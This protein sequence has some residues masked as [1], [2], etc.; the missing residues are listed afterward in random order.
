MRVA[1]STKGYQTISGH[2]GQT[3]YW[4][5]YDLTGCKAGQP[6]PAPERVELEKAQV[7]HYFDGEGPHPLDGV[8]LVI[9]ASAGDGF[10]RRMQKRGADVL[11]TGESDPAAAIGLVLAGQAQPVPKFDIT[12]SFCKVFDLFSKH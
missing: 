12:T 5:I 1:V 2:A 6:L 3:R 11:K 4:L 10:I 7:I 9:T 8:R